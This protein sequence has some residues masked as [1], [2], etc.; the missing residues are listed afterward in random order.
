M[1]HGIGVN[2]LL[3]QSTRALRTG[4]IT[5]RHPWVQLDAL[6]FC[7]VEISLAFRNRII[8]ESI[9]WRTYFLIGE[10]LRSRR[11]DYLPTCSWMRQPF[12]FFEQ[13]DTLEI[14]RPECCLGHAGALNDTNCACFHQLASL[15]SCTSPEA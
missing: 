5:P 3:P 14:F 2:V 4:V 8:I 6:M 10:I 1:A 11:A 12:A 7:Y 9:C 15:C 13:D